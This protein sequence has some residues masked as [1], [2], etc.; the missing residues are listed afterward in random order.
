MIKEA[1]ENLIGVNGRNCTG[2]T[3]NGIKI[4]FW[5]SSNSDEIESAWIKL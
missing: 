5:K 3:S 1:S 2:V 4:E